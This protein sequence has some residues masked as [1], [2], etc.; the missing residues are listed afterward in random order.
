[1]R[2][3]VWADA[4]A[5]ET[6]SAKDQ[7]KAALDGRASSAEATALPEI[8]VVW[9]PHPSD[10]SD[11]QRL[12]HLA[13]TDGGPAL[14]ETVLAAI[15][16]AR[17]GEGADVTDLE[18]L[19]R[20]SASA[21]FAQGAA[22]L[23]TDAGK[24]GVE[25]QRL[26]G[27]AIGVTAVPTFTQADRLLESPDSEALTAFL[28]AEEERAVPEETQR[29][30]H[31]EA[32]LRQRDPLGALRLIEPLLRDHPGHP[33][34]VQLAARAYFKS[35]QLNKAL[36]LAEAMVEVNPADFYARRLLGR[37]LERL[38]RRDEARAHLRLIDEITED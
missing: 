16:A 24:R 29:L 28:D 2:I 14:Q 35:A 3:E 6:L 37:T 27:K 13:Y 21:G 7:L 8:E 33:D 5:P 19:G 17:Y 25:E 1:M 34:V 9:R 30:R 23:R 4:V 11:A 12:V 15:L 22:M 32:L 36:V 18:V 10:D 20:L 26:R 31:A 38:G